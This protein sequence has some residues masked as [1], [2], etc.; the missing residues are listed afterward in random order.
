MKK[1]EPVNSEILVRVHAAGITGDEVLW[2]GTYR[3]PTRIPGHDISGVIAAFGPEY[4]GPL[5]IGQEV[6][7]FLTSHHGEGQA[8]Y[9]ACSSE[10]VALK[11]ASLSH[12]EAAT[13]PIPVLTAWEILDY[14]DFH[15]GTRVLV[16][17][18]SGAVGQQFVQLVKQ[19]ADAY[20]IALA[21]SDNP[22]TQQLLGKVVDEVIDYKTPNWEN[23]VQNIDVVFD[24]VGGEVL[25]KT[26]ETVKADGTIITIGDPA[27]A[28]AY[29]NDEAPESLTYPGVKYKYFI[30][31]PNAQRLGEIV[32]MFD[33]GLMKPLAVKTFPFEQ[34]AE[35]WE[36]ARQRGK[37]YKVV[38][39]L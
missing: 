5:K 30:V 7:A 12:A 34:A 18:A 19:L 35:A 26:W 16:T 13:L 33:E 29:G 14:A 10:E 25:A 24:T 39:E 31:S 6:F 9:V 4:S 3:R 15:S 8:E 11:P 17:G 27:P 38:L 1:P 28:W 2:G 32:K 37:T 21:S 36:D 23:T 20:V 22:V